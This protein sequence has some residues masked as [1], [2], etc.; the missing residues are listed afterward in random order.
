[1]RLSL[2]VVY[3]IIYVSAISGFGQENLIELATEQGTSNSLEAEFGLPE[4]LMTV[5]FNVESSTDSL[6]LF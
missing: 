3:L 6:F 1:M 5:E 2:S 4:Y